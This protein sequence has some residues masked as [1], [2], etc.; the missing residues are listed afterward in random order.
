MSIALPQCYHE[1]LAGRV[2]F[3][4]VNTIVHSRKV[5][6][7]PCSFVEYHFVSLILNSRLYKLH[8]ILVFHL[9]SAY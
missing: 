2:F 6:L 4:I 9:Y 7:Y 3:F 5:L 8:D 1:A